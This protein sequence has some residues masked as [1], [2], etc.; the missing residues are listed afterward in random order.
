MPPSG[1]TTDPYRSY[2]VD[3][4]VAGFAQ[5]YEFSVIGATIKESA[6]MVTTKPKQIFHVISRFMVGQG[7]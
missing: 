7:L 4:Q 3:Q 5:T 1:E 2:S 6:H